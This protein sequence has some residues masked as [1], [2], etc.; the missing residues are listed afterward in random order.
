VGVANGAS[1]IAVV[2]DLDERQTRMLFMIGAQSAVIRAPPL[3]W[4]V[5][6]YGHFRRLQEDLSASTVV[7]NVIGNKHSLAPVDGA[8]F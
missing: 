5:I 6:C 3:Y 4:R 8:V 7:V 2:I 1:Q